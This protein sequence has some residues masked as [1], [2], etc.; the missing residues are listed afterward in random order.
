MMRAGR[1]ALMTATAAVFVWLCVTAI[2]DAQQIRQQWAA[3]EDVDK[4]EMELAT[5][6]AKLEEHI[7]SDYKRFSELNQADSVR[8]NDLDKRLALMESTVAMN[9]RILWGVMAAVGL[10]LA[11]VFFGLFKIEIVKRKRPEGPEET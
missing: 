6:R 9:N 1:I 11:H 8:M 10:Q 4:I 7:L 5:E 2:T 3:Q